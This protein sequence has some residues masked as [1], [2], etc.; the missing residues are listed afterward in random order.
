MTVKG[1]KDGLDGIKYSMKTNYDT[2]ELSHNG[3]DEST[4]MVS[5][6]GSVTATTKGARQGVL[7]VYMNRSSSYPMTTSDGNSDT[8]VKIFVYNRS[9]SEDYCRQRALEI[10]TETRDTGAGSFFS[11]GIYCAVKNRSGTS[12][13]NSGHIMAA[14]F[15]TDMQGTGTPDVIGVNIHDISQATSGSLT[16][17]GLKI[18][19]ANYAITRDYAIHVSSGGGSWT[20]IIAL[21]DD[22]H[23][24]FVY[25]AVEGGCVGTTR[26]SPNQTATCDGSLKVLVGSKTLY[27]PLYN[28]VSVS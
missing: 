4:K 8:G 5:L 25:G 10:T 2:W 17:Y 14:K 13:N 22:D 11:E 16:F 26:T 19:S 28:A 20:N 24:N 23:T 21:S 7:Y 9:A 18:S 6:S 3:M 27:I 15:E 1:L 12:I